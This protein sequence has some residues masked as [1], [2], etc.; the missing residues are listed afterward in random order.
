MYEIF[1]NMVMKKLEF[2]IL[3]M[4]AESSNYSVMGYSKTLF[5]SIEEVEK[6]YD[7]L[8]KD[9]FVANNLITKKGQEVLDSHRIDNAIIL[10]AG[11][12][13]RFVPLNF[14]KPKGLL[15]VKGEIL[16]ERQIR[17][18][19]EKGINDI[20][21]VV[22]Y[23]K[24][25]FE[26]LKDKYGVI[27]VPTDDYD[28]KNNFAS[29]YAARDFL[30]NSIVTSSDLY[31]ENNIFQKYAYDSYYCTIYVEGKTAER[32]IRTDNDD[33][34][35][36]TMYGDK[37]YDIWVTLGY[38]FFSKCF[39][40]RMISIIDKIKDFPE[41]A[42]MFWADIQDEHLDELYMYAKRC[43]VSDIQ[44]FDSLEELRC[45]DGKYIYNSGSRIL[46][47]ISAILSVHENDIT[48]LI[49]LRKY[50]S[51]M[52]KF[53]LNDSE[54][55]CDVN[56]DDR[57][58]LSY[59]N[60]IYK[61][62]TNYVTKEMQLYKL[63]EYS[64][65]TEFIDTDK[66]VDELCRLVEDFEEYHKEALP[67]C[68]AENVISPFANLPL[69]LGFQERYIMNNTYSFNM[70]DNFIGCEK[71]YPFYKKLSD[72]CLRVFGA[73]YTDARPFTGMHC[74]DMITKTICKPGD[75]MM[76][77]SK[78]YGGHAS[79]KPVVERLGV[80]TY[81]APYDL[82]EN[83][84]DY[85]G[86]N[87]MIS[88]E[89]IKYI[90][91]APSDLIKPL[92]VEL[93][94]TKNCILLY[95]CSQVMGLI[96]AKLCPNPLL[97]MDNIIMFGGTH[98]TFPGPASGLIMTNDEKLHNLME[99]EINPKYLRH[100]QMHQ[101]ISLLFALIEF[102]RYGRDYMLKMVESANYI[103]SKLRE[104]GFDI[105]D[106][107]GRISETHQ[108]HILTSKSLMDTIYENASKCKITLNKKH[109]NLFHGYGI[110]LG[111]Q[112]IARYGWEKEALDKISL[113]IKMI[114][115]KDVDVEKVRRLIK[116]LPP[117][118]IHYV[119]PQSYVERFR[120]V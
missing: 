85:K 120:C 8:Q 91:L 109:K 54:Y 99:T 107:H 41:T 100:S 65:I 35:I 53:K 97:T 4:I 95:D 59:N 62:C 82:A 12:S 73:Q 10:A 61:R 64:D 84:L 28:K 3:S 90:L 72:V 87:E 46:S 105:S 31:F 5:K 57:V 19:K 36:K 55:I 79:V 60:N 47:A 103:G 17:Q 117:K 24:E 92:N 38:A 48:N 89:G 23:M 27:L 25:K 69:T 50:K 110:R 32:G 56:P 114:A 43:N 7:T 14:E 88:S 30:G 101:K 29:V 49:S 111:T 51:S 22:G 9:G 58:T 119:F 44:E 21:L 106:I 45:Y 80:T 13:T 52:F 116:E 86:V 113:A 71:L 20:I 96:A 67:L 118:D 108:V 34:I 94:N 112:E 37:C 115:E 42:G 33:K 63:Q 74:I 6:A 18:L 93:I 11:M 78:E 104:Y 66:E 68:A 39:S 76:I 81:D 16:V 77:L 15:E 98:K 26:Y 70:D 83:D 75:K 102:E 40:E 1:N 2:D